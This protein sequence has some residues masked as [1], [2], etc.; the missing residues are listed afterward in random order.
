MTHSKYVEDRPS[1][2]HEHG[3]ALPLFA[4]AFV[5]IVGFAGM[6]LD[7]ARLY[8]EHSRLQVAA[9]SA[10]IGAAH[11][12]RRGRRDYSRNLLPAAIHDAGLHGV[13]EADAE[14]IV[15]HPPV[16][17]AFAQSPHHVEV[18]VRS[19]FRTTF[20]AMFGVGRQPV[21]S[22]AVAGLAADQ[23]PCLSVF[24]SD[25][26][27]V[28]GEQPFEVAC[29]VTVEDAI[30]PF[31]GLTMPSCVGRAVGSEESGDGE[32]L[33]WPGC[34]ESPVAV[35]SGRARFM[36]GVHIFLQG[37]TI[38][39]GEAHGDGVAF[40]FPASE[41]QTGVTIAAGAQVSLA[42][43]VQGEL[44]G[45]LFFAEAGGAAPDALIARGAGS[46]FQG[47]FYFPGRTLSWAPNAPGSPS[48]TQAAAEKLVI[49]EAP[50]GRAVG[51][52][53]A[54]ASAALTA[55]LVE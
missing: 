19:D 51:A 12:L 20:M 44:A 11:E 36:P 15:H 18:V 45:M 7:G 1:G 47:A 30:D 29:E 46:E 28:E 54:D 23:P 22:R 4:I 5:A 21:S 38:T 24:G 31:T 52:S 9:D 16:S 43:P 14:I 34:H 25:A 48:W 27:A 42:A 37:L 40:L 41:R 6:A 26:Y 39:G 35:A 50:D 53:P 2:R 10:A 32:T 3:Q 13:T 49:L 17:G 8:A 55:V 33:Y